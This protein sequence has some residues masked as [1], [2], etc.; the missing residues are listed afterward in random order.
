[1]K[2]TWWKWNAAVLVVVFALLSVPSYAQLSPAQEGASTA[3]LPKAIGGGA[4][5]LYGVLDQVSEGAVVVDDAEYPLSKKC[6]VFDKHENKIPK[7]RLMP[8]T[9]IGFEMNSAGVVTSIYLIEE[10]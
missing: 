8:N 10:L 4:P 6:Q 7:S 1:M 3:D 9:L 2:T 5:L